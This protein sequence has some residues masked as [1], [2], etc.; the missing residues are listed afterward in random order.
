MALEDE[1][2]EEGSMQ[3]ARPMLFRS[4]KKSRLTREQRSRRRLNFSSLTD[5]EEEIGSRRQCGQIFEYYYQG[6]KTKLL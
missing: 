5:A 1:K 4:G 2:P 3:P 6:I